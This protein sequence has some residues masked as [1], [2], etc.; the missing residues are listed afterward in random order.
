MPQKSD[1]NYLQFTEIAGE[2]V[3]QEQVDRMIQRYA[4]AGRY[5]LGKDVLEVA[6]G[7]GQGLGY[8][9]KVSNSIKAGDVS[10]ELVNIAKGIYNDSIQII[11]LDAHKLSFD[12]DSFDVILLFEAIYYLESPEIFVQECARVLRPNGKVLIATANKD[13]YD[14]N[15]SLHT[16]NYYGGA[17]L[18]NLFSPVG[19]RVRLFGDT[20]LNTVSLRQRLLRPLKRLAV[21]FNLIPKTMGGKRLLKR[22]VFGRMV[23]MPTQL[24]IPTDFVYVPSEIPA[25]Q[26]DHKHKVLLCEAT[27]VQ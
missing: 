1:T 9:A 8:L 12:N 7:T 2:E 26:P 15:P 24:E 4:W 14:F 17:D 25:G 20:P 13:L 19:F 18:P 27:L 21:R 11:E 23:P 10:P 6:C 3:S 16:Y 5:C 22:L